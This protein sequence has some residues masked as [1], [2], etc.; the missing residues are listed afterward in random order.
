[1]QFS[2]KYMST[3]KGYPQWD[4]LT[5]RFTLE[6]I[7]HDRISTLHGSKDKDFIISIFKDDIKESLEYFERED[8]FEIC[9]LL[10]D[11]LHHL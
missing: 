10:K 11:L 9:Q 6:K 1:M 7:V 4:P 3:F 5:K 2:P 8:E